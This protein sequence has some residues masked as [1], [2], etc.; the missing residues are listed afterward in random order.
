MKKEYL[1]ASICM[2][3]LVILDAAGDAFRLRG[4]QI[5][6]HEAEVHVIIGFFAAWALFG[7]KWVYVWLY[8]LA[9]VAIF[10]L[11]F[12]LVAGN[13]PFYVGDSG[14]YDIALRWFANLVR[15]GPENIAF[16][17]TFMASLSWVGVYLKKKS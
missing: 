17:L 3:L 8:A 1:I 4:W 11:V 10:A 7:F 5:I 12:N 14:G 16:I 6:H 15:V 9:R 2:V 13:A